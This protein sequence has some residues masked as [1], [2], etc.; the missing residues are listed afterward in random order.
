MIPSYN[1]DIFQRIYRDMLEI[2]NELEKKQ[3]PEHEWI[4]FEDVQR[5][6]IE[7]E[8]FVVVDDLNHQEEK[9]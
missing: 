5:T 1:A 3:Q 7:N 8:Q 9:K 2:R 6:L 4:D